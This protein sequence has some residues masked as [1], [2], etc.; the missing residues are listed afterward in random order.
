MSSPVIPPPYRIDNETNRDVV[1]EAQALAFLAATAD[2][3]DL[4][5]RG[6]RMSVLRALGRLDEAEREGREAYDRARREGTPRQ[7]VAALIRLAHVM[8]Y[9]R[10]FATADAMFTQA[11][12]Q[13]RQLG[14]PLLLAF[15]HQH[16]GRNLLE[17][18]RYAEAVEAFEAAL[19]LRQA[20]GAPADQLESTRG[21]LEVARRRPGPGAAAGGAVTG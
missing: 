20:H 11:L 3:T 5:T 7:Q 6:Q 13:A 21:A 14:D 4:A 10:D 2:R 12:A 19:L 17:Q 8:Q 15:A 18:G 16:A 9:R 1:D